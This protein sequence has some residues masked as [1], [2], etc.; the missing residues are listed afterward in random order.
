MTTGIIA[1]G[2][3]A[4]NVGKTIPRTMAPNSSK[5]FSARLFQLRTNSSSVSVFALMERGGDGGGGRHRLVVT[6]HPPTG[7]DRSSLVAR[8]QSARRSEVETDGEA[9]RWEIKKDRLTDDWDPE[10]STD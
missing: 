8:R 9:G 2:E 7:A 1:I 5:S 3:F 10:R 6:A 4:K